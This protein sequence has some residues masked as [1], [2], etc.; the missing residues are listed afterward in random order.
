MSISSASSS[1]S[2]T[3]QWQQQK[4]SLGQL[5]GAL[6][7]GNLSAAQQAFTSLSANNPAANDP[8]SPLGKLGA[9]LQSGNMSAA[10]Q[11]FSTMQ[12]S[13]TSQ[14]S[15]T[16]GAGHYH[17]QGG[18]PAIATSTQASLPLATSGSVGT[19]INTTA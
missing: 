3:S 17:H 12:T 16:Q 11:A 18:M 1:V 2:G 19:K 4:S 14:A 9:A 13:A 5:S 7:S 8:N 10:Q 15:S 6:K